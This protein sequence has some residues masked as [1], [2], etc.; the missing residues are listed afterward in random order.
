MF[1]GEES[2]K[3][4]LE[5]G[6][7]LTANFRNTLMNSFGG[8]KGGYMGKSDMMDLLN[9]TEAVGF[10]YYYGLKE[11]NPIVPQLVIVGVD[12]DGN[13]LTDG[14]ILDKSYTCPAVCSVDNPLNTSL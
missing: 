10:R 6:A 9:Q 11:G 5:E 8:I 14:I 2:N 3:I 7:E 13:D 4:T 1:T 12:A